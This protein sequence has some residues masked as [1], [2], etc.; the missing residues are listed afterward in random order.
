MATPL[1]QIKNPSVAD[2]MLL[3]RN[4]TVI[5]TQQEL[6]LAIDFI[7]KHGTPGEVESLKWLLQ[8]DPIDEN[9]K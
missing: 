5:Q 4:R 2:A 7:N 1:S 6:K 8:D 3:I 9:R